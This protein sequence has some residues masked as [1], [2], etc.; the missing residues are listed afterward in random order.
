MRLEA[1]AFPEHVES[2][3]HLHVVANFA[4]R[5]WGGRAISHEQESELSCIWHRVTK[6]SGTSVIKLAQ[7]AGWA[8]YVTKEWFRSDHDYIHSADF[9]S[10]RYVVYPVPALDGLTA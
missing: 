1:V 2:N 10:D 3:L 4:R 9:H 7:N 5:Y 8:R 6:G